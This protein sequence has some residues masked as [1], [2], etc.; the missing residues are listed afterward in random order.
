M[1]WLRWSSCRCE[2]GIVVVVPEVEVNLV[3]VVKEPMALLVVLAAGPREP[4]VLAASDVAE[5]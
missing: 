1:K 4:L 3:E 2:N 5:V